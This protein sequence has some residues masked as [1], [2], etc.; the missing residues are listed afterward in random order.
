MNSNYLS[1]VR[2]YVEDLITNNYEIIYTPIKIDLI[3]KKLNKL[4]DKYHEM[5]KYYITL[6]N[7]T[8]HVSFNVGLEQLDAMNRTMFKI[9]IFKNIDEEAILLVS[10]EVTEHSQWNHIYVELMKL[11]KFD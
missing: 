5:C 4:F 9:K 3:E 2:F 7:A 11:K 10:N 6:S 8:Y 1:C